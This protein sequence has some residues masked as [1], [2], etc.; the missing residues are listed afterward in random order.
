MRRAQSTVEYMIT[1]SV[2]TIAIIAVMRAMTYTIYEGTE[3]VAGSLETSL[4]EDGV[5]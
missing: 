4:T 2:I 3:Q 5:Q 1:I